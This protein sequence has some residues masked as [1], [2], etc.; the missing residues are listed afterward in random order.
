MMEQRKKL[1]WQK[2]VYPQGVSSGIPLFYADTQFGR[3]ELDADFSRQ[4]GR[5]WAFR[6][7][8]T[9][10]M[11]HWHHTQEE[12]QEAAQ[13]DFDDRLAEDEDDKD[14]IIHIRHKHLDLNKTSWC[15]VDLNL[16]WAFENIDHAAYN[17]RAQGRLVACRACTDAVIKCLT[18]GQDD[19]G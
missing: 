1:D 9:E 15:G 2:S 13:A 17:G 3:Y 16:D 7:P 8:D 19:G 11:S 4:S 12:A 6:V 18:E 14:W 5:I 10:E